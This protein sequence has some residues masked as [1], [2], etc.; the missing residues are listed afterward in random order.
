MCVAIF[1]TSTSTIP[2]DNIRSAGERNNHGFGM[3]W[4]END[5][6]KCYKT[7]GLESLVSKYQTVKDRVK[8]T[9]P[10][11]LHCRFGTQ[12]EKNLTNCHPF[13][14]T[15][16]LCMIHNGVIYKHSETSKY[17]DTALFTKEIES[18]ADE[19]VSNPTVHTLIQKYVGDS[20]KL[21]FLNNKKQYKIINETKGDWSA[22]VW[23]SNSYWK[24][25]YTPSET[26]GNYGYKY[27]RRVSCKICRELF[28]LSTG[29][30][31]DGLKFTHYVCGK[32]ATSPLNKILDVVN[33]TM[34]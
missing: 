22:G 32:C 11:I 21:I 23:Y 17:S 8:E 12:G 20:N 19:V 3:A 26:S 15:P 34:M 24:T 30:T 25:T 28:E 31:V 1:Q 4:V 2:L 16:N 9:T 27:K 29:I 33:P 5:I 18:L 14:V 6:L 10:I 7:I 13:F